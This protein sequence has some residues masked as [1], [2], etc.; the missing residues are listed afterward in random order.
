MGSE[1]DAVEGPDIP[2]RTQEVE[3][4]QE[5]PELD[6]YAT[7]PQLDE[8]DE[9]TR[10][11]YELLL[12]ET[13]M[14]TD[15][16]HA[17]AQMM[18]D[19]LAGVNHH[20]L[21]ATYTEVDPHARTMQDV[22][23]ATDKF[24]GN[25]GLPRQMYPSADELADVFQGTTSNMVDES[26]KNV[27]LHVDHTPTQATDICYDFDSLLA[28]PDSLEALKTT[29]WYSPVQNI[30]SNV[31]TDVHVRRKCTYTTADGKTH[32]VLHR[33]CDIPHVGL[34]RAEGFQ[35]L[36]VTL[37][38]PRLLDPTRPFTAI[39]GEQMRRFTNDAMLLTVKWT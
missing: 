2:S 29:I 15:E 37:F 3:E 35:N 38:F 18:H 32:S 22:G 1:S 5:I 30:E 14:C 12:V 13:P 24:P 17:H 28:F 23:L 19:V 39:T 4:Q 20:G 10:Q 9:L 16:D 25:C 7:S 33:L 31:K 36:Q 26:V 34:G 21:A 8:Q 11:V 6:A 27:C